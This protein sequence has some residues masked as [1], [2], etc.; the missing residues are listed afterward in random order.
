MCWP[1]EDEAKTFI[2]FSET[3]I[4]TLEDFIVWTY[5]AE[6]AISTR[7]KFEDV[8]ELAIFADHH[9]IEAL[10]NQA[11]D[12]LRHKF[13]KGEWKLQPH[14]VERV[15]SAMHPETPLRRLIRMLL[16]T[17]QKDLK[18]DDGRRREMDSWAAVFETSSKIGRDYYVAT[19]ETYTANQVLN[20]GPCRYHWHQYPSRQ[21][22]NRIGDTVCPFV[23]G[24]CF[25]DWDEFVVP[26]DLRK[27]K[28]GAV[29]VKISK[30]E[31][32]KSKKAKVQLLEN[33]DDDD[34]A[35]PI[36]E[37]Q[38]ISESVPEIEASCVDGDYGTTG[39]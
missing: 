16:N 13:G 30:R 11:L 24:A 31:K 39:F 2:D 35:A 23:Y 36:E 7:A 3:P 22:V 9:F 34:A 17:A 6:P 20:G 33:V 12:V 26:E 14:V 8:V 29:V 5:A 38:L 37:S 32:K 10:H 4:G 19:C 21:D 25:V 27:G 1:S 28:T 15:Y 18:Y